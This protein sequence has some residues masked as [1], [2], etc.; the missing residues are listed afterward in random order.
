MFDIFKIFKSDKPNVLVVDDEPNIVETLQDRLEM[1][2]YHVITAVNGE[3]G[4][5]KASQHSLDIVLLDIMMP[6]MD[7]L[8][9]LERLRQ[10][11]DNADVPVIMLSACSQTQDVARAK[12]FGIE[13][14]IVKPFDLAELMGKIDNILERKKSLVGV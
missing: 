6:V 2:G 9:M 5:E 7:G 13:D 14:Y 4:L 1:S 11:L 10:T 8:E 12:A 3:D